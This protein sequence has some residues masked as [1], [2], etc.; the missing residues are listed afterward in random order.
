MKKNTCIC[1]PDGYNENR[2][3]S[4][5]AVPGLRHLFNHRILTNRRN[6]AF[7]M[8]NFAFIFVVWCCIYV[9]QVI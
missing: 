9:K 1:L 4:K 6:T 5:P 7:F 2:R 3:S 8:S